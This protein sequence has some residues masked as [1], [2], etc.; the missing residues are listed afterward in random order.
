MQY[1]SERLCANVSYFISR[2]VRMC[3]MLCKGGSLPYVP[4]VLMFAT[5]GQ[6]E[7]KGS[8]T[9]LWVGQAVKQL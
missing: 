7:V 5:A 4:T 2:I 1:T 3:A 8:N 9:I 6:D